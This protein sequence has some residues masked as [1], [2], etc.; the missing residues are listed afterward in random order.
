MLILTNISDEVP[1]CIPCGFL[2][3]LLVKMSQM[4]VTDGEQDLEF[5]YLNPFQYIVLI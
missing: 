5:T 3:K 1:F 2:Y 4:I